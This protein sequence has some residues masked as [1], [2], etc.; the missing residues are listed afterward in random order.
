MRELWGYIDW[1]ECLSH[2]DVQDS[3]T[4]FHDPLISIM[5]DC[6]PKLQIGGHFKQKRNI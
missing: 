1:V 5:D 4:F 6:I 2:S 3:W